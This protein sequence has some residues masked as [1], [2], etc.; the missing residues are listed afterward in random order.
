MRD[1]MPAPGWWIAS[2]GNW[3]P[4][5]LHPDVRAA[6]ITTALS[7]AE[8]AVSASPAA[9]G[10][11]AT[12]AAA[13][14][15]P[16]TRLFTPLIDEPSP[17]ESLHVNGT[18]NGTAAAIEGAFRNGA[19]PLG[20]ATVTAPAPDAETDVV[21]APVPEVPIAAPDRARAPRAGR[22]A[23]AISLALLALAIIVLIAQ[24]SDSRP[25]LEQAVTTTV[26]TDASAAPTTGPA[27]ANGNPSASSSTTATAGATTS[28]TRAG[29]TTA[30]TVAGAR[31][32]PRT[33]SVFDL[34]KGNCLDG[35]TLSDGLI[36]TIRLVDCAEPH[37]HEV[38]YSGRYPETSFDSEKIASYANTTCLAQFTPYVGIDY[39][40]SRYQYLH[41]VPTQ[42]S[43]TRDNDRDVVCVA[44]E[45]NATL[46]G[47]IANRAQ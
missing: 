5:E 8:T 26:A 6:A 38:F 16:L 47:S 43:W 32:A 31:V 3:Y 40:R 15:K 36:T 33:V 35:A 41:I 21:D 28:T 14:D 1:G 29:A 19:A 34:V 2:D 13:V 10:P 17:F 24:G 11:T 9:A 18:A 37:T 4:P 44:F 39:A 45:E 22:R 27:A 30:P 12:P 46:T 42:E 7:A 23:Y 20:V 25:S